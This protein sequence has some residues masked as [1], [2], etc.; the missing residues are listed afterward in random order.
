MSK[1]SQINRFA[2]LKVF[3]S[4]LKKDVLIELRNGESLWSIVGLSIAL[5]SLAGVG[6]KNSIVQDAVVGPIAAVMI[7]VIFFAAASL[8]TS[9]VFD[10]DLKEGAL[11][12]LILAK[13]P[14]PLIFLSK[15]IVVWMLSLIG[16]PITTCILLLILNC[17]EFKPGV[18]AIL[19]ASVSLGYAFLA[20]FV[21]MMTAT[22]RLKALL[23]AIVL[24]PLLFPLFFCA[25]ELSLA[26]IS[27]ENS[28]SY[29]NLISSAW[30][31]IIWALNIGYALIGTTL[32]GYTVRG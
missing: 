5:S 15:S 26:M 24:P 16:A 27:V 21:S 6:L 22:A 3:S 12:Q 18:L 28:T 13:V 4:L 17:S 11:S 10:E 29:Q 14:T 30:F 19:I 25:S 32:F 9:K 20:T 23:L 8:A 31:K 7:W 2:T 1:Q